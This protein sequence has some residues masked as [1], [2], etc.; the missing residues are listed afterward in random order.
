MGERTN[1]LLTFLNLH[2]IFL[3]PDVT[4]VSMLTLTPT[5]GYDDSKY[6]L[7]TW[8]GRGQLAT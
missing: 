8:L 1:K 2:D 3:N 6:N 7:S 5:G 4:R